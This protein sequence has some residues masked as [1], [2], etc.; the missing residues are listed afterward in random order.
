MAHIA[1]ISAS[2]NGNR[3]YQRGLSKQIMKLS[4][5]KASGSTQRNGITATSWHILLVVAMS[6]TEAQDGK[7]IHNRRAKREVFEPAS[8]VESGL[9]ATGGAFSRLIAQK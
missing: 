2:M 3:T 5:Y 4:R 9:D 1:V 7:R 6:R 8:G